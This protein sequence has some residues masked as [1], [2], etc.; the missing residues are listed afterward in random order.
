MVLGNS[1]TPGTVTVQGNFIGTAADGTTKLGN[2]L[3]GVEV[4][5]F[6]GTGADDLSPHAKLTGN[7]ISG[8]ARM[9]CS[10]LV[11]HTT[12]F[13]PTLSAR[14]APRRPISATAHP[15]NSTECS[16]RTPV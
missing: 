7:V 4:D 11:A 16:F 5:G 2:A 6:T 3:S 10:S 15:A 14:T 8:T 12:S 13:N 1:P 9:A